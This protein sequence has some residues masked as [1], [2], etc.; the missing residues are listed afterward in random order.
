MPALER[1]ERPGDRR[2]VG[3]VLTVPGV[4]LG[5]ADKVQEAPARDRVVDEMAAGPDPRLV[6]QFEPEV[7]DALDWHQPA[8]GDAAGKARRLLA[9]QLGAHRRVD[10]VGADQHIAGDPRAV[11]EPCLDFRALVGEADQPVAEM[12][13]L[14][15]KARGDHRQQIG[16]VNGDVRRAV[17]CFALR[18]ERRLLQGAPVLPAA[19]VGPERADALAVETR[20]EAEPP[21]HARRI[22]THVDAAADLR[23]LGRLFV[24]LDR[25]PGLVQRHGGAEAA[26]AAA[27]NRDVEPLAL[28][29]TTQ[30]AADCRSDHKPAVAA[31]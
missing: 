25:E 12:H 8:I 26:K 13:P 1:G 18:V 31:R 29:L 28:H 22:R 17:K 24:D 6:A 14:G 3:P 2:A 16:A 15:R 27:D 23:Q 21:Q 4:V 9:E 10:A 7:G 5:P 11:V 19:L 30:E 20:P